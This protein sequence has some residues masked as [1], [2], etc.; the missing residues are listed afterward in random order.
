MIHRWRTISEAK[1]H[2][3]FQKV[4]VLAWEA[5]CGSCLVVVRTEWPVNLLVF[6]AM[7]N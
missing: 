5:E 4:A 1:L 3:Q 2:I 7:A 6:A